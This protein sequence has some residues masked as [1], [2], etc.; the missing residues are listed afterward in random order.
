MMKKY[1]IA[2]EEIIVD[3]F[4]VEANNYGEAL[5]VAEEKYFKGEFV[6]CPGEIQFRKMAVVKPDVI[7]IK[8]HEF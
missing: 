4:E 6:L 8:W 1:I 5:Q 7:D 3:E 2:I